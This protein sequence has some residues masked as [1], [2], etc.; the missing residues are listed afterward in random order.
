MVL[1]NYSESKVAHTNGT[2][3][4]VLQNVILNELK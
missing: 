1:K 4:K 3:V 2:Q